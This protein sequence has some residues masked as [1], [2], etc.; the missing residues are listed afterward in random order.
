MGKLSTF[1]VANFHRVCELLTYP[2][3]HQ[4]ARVSKTLHD[5]MIVMR[6]EWKLWPLT[7][8]GLVTVKQSF[9]DWGQ[10]ANGEKI[11]LIAPPHDEA[12][13]EKVHHQV[14]R[15]IICRHWIKVRR[16]AII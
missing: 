14:P 13:S 4:M 16:K 2:D 11:I 12:P 9:V 5:S 10:L 1:E 8:R 6:K 7:P 3:G 15:K